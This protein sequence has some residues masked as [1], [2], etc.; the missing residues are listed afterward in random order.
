MDAAHVRRLPKGPSRVCGRA[1][2]LI[3]AN[4]AVDKVNN[5]WWTA[6]MWACFLG[7][8][9]CARALID[10]NAAVDHEDD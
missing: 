2:A 10:A 4:A 6:L 1:Q 3:D 9:E 8:H 5:D 7:H